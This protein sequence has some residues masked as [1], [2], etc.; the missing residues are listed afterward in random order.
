VPLWDLPAGKASSG[1]GTDLS[2]CDELVT[3]QA[4]N[5]SLI[6]EVDKILLPCI[7]LTPVYIAMLDSEV[8]KMSHAITILVILGVEEHQS[9]MM[10]DSEPS[11]RR[12][13]DSRRRRVG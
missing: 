2:S 4:K 5:K 6:T 8:S 13:W 9:V 3:V 1:P 11:M 7:S 10:H 12:R